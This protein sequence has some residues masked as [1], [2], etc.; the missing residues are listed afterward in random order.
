VT[1]KRRRIGDWEGDTIIDKIIGK[2]I[3]K[4]ITK[5]IGNSIPKNRQSAWLTLVESGSYT[6]CFTSSKKPM[7]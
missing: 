6:V 2:K 4:K 5:K 3:T 7:Y 1:D